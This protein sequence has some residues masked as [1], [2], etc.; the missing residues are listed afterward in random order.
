M[1]RK[2]QFLFVVAAVVCAG[3][4]QFVIAQSGTRSYPQAQGTQATQGSASRSP[5]RAPASFDDRFWSY[6]RQAQYQNWASLPGVP[7]DGFAGKS[8]HGERVKLYVNRAATAGQEGFRTGSILVKENYDATGKKLMAVTVMY[9]AE[10][11]APQT[12]NWYWA[13]YDSSGRVSVMNNMRVSGRVGMCIDCHQSAQG[14]DFVFAN[15][16]Q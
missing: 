5:S 3:L 9:R 11:F 10:G 1:I 2:P 8:P 6:L 7:A 14:N 12:G 15:D 16:R 13:K 4:A